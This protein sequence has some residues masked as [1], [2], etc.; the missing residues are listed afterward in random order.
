MPEVPARGTAIP[1]ADAAN[2]RAL[3]RSIRSGQTAVEKRAQA[4]IALRE[5]GYSI[6]AIAA[7]CGIN[8]E[9]VRKSIMRRTGGYAPD[10]PVTA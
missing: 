8:K 5:A 2:L 6:D 1:T 10:K 3:T 7:A 9:Q 4:F